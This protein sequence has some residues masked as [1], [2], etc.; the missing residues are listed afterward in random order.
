MGPL[1]SA[2]SD[3][4][5]APK[6]QRKV[7]SLQD[8]VELFDRHCRVRSAAVIA[9]YLKINESRVETI[10]K[11][12]KKILG[13]INAATPSGPKTLNILQNTFISY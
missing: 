11:M 4:G 6:L 2:T 9:H 7:M 3:V 5:S 1:Q 13:G 10:I 12:E 8:K